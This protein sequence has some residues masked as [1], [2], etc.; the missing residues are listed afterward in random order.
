VTIIGT[1]GSAGDDYTNVCEWCRRPVIQIPGRGRPRKYCKRSCRQRDFEARQLAAVRG[2]DENEILLARSSLNEL[3][4]EIYILSCALIDAEVDMLDAA[5]VEQV[6]A[7]IRPLM[8]S[9]QRL[10]TLD[11]NRR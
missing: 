1:D 10:T 11:P 3:K 7:A 2:L 8:E 5:T 6:R 9:A 4:D